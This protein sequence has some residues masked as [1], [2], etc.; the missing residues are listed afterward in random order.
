MSGRG[1]ELAQRRLALQER[2][3]RQRGELGLATQT[4]ERQLSLVDHGVAFI[5]RVVSAP[6]LIAAAVA[7]VLLVRPARLIKWAGNV[8]IL[9]AAYKRLTREE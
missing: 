1:G 2:C 4:L 5:R 6:V 3:A 9:G 8:V 7:I